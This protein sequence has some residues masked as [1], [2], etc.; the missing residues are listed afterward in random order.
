[1]KKRILTTFLTTLVAFLI[2]L[3]GQIILMLKFPDSSML[4]SRIWV[5][6][7]VVLACVW[8]IAR[9]FRNEKKRREDEENENYKGVY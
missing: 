8:D 7:V 3:I 4:V 2:W 1:M 9:H 6:T 5:I